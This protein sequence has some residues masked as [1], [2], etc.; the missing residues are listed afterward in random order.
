MP[1]AVGAGRHPAEDADLAGDGGGPVTGALQ[2]LPGAFQEHP[3]LWVGDLRLA[4][5]VTE[6]RGVEQ[7]GAVQRGASSHISGVR[8]ERGRH[9][10]GGEFVL[11]DLP[12]AAG[13]GG[14][15]AP[16]RGDVARAGEPAGHAHDGEL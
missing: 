3:V 4:W 11:G 6:E 15:V 9:L 2:S 7:I 10:G 16:E 13:T 14:E 12:D 8:L 5:A 1:H